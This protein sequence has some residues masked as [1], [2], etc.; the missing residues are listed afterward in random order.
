MTAFCHESNS[1]L[2]V[3]DTRKRYIPLESNPEVFTDLITNLG[4]QALKF[5]D[6]Y[7]I[8]EPDLMAMVDRP[9]LALV[10]VFPVTDND[11]EYKKKNWVEHYA[12]SGDGEPVVWYRQTIHNACGLYAILH[13]ISNGQ[14]RE[15]IRALPFRLVGL[16]S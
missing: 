16:P 13:G 11:E 12:G 7:S 10:L 3:K 6:V 15:F 14:A 8:D 1:K 5:Q 2:A 9:V 4:V